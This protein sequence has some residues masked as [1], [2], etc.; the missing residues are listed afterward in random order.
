MSEGHNG[1]AVTPDSPPVLVAQQEGLLTLTLNRPKTGNALSAAMVEAL[2]DAID[3]AAQDRTIHTLLL[4]GEG[5]HF[6]TGFDLAD[7]DRTTDGELLHRF[8]RI[9]TLLAAL[10]HAPQRT[11]VLVHGHAWGA[12]ADLVA[13]C[14]QRAAAPIATFRFPGA[15]FGLVLGSRRLAERVGADV[16]RTWIT[17]AAVV[18]AD[19]AASHGLVSTVVDDDGADWLSQ[20][21]T[22]PAVDPHTA[23]AIRAATRPDHRDADLAAL[24]RSAAP[25]GLRQ[26][27]A[28]YAARARA[29]RAK[30]VPN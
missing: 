21:T 22:P 1:A 30:P 5:R 6:C 16:A 24:V 17:L 10:W 23:A 7:L 15:Q 13:V 4:R 11:A 9:E 8:V 27:I 26:R 18:D 28:D 2:L 25:P 29:S 19:D 20:L 3:A 12:G 14:E